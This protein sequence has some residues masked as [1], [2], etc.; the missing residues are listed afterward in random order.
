ML[1]QS[2]FGVH[3]RSHGHQ[4]CSEERD[5]FHSLESLLF[6]CEVVRVTCIS[7]AR[8]DQQRRTTV[9]VLSAPLACIL[10]PRCVHVSVPKECDGNET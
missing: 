8:R 6:I 5:C 2:H 9:L 3:K 7:S 4:Q 1:A 10:L